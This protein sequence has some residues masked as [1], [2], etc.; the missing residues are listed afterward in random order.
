MILDLV[1]SCNVETKYV[2]RVGRQAYYILN[3]LSTPNKSPSQNTILVHAGLNAVGQ[4]TIAIA[5]AAG[6]VV[7]TTVE[8]EEQAALLRKRFPSVSV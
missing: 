2:L 5:L 1:P 7:Y 3:V 8:S 4:A 6:D